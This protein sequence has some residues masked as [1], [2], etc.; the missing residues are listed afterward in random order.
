MKYE[1]DKKQFISIFDTFYESG[2]PF[3]FLI[4]FNVENFFIDKLKNLE[5]SREVLYFFNGKTNSNICKTGIDSFYL[6]KYPIERSLYEKK[7]DRIMKNLKE[8]DSYLL[9]L[10]FPT[11][12]ET[13]LTFE[14]IFLYA[15]ASYK[16][17]MYDDFLFFSPERFITIEN[18]IISTFPMKGTRELLNENSKRLLVEDEKELAEHITVVDLLRNDLSI[19]ADDVRVEKFR[20][21]SEIKKMGTTLLQTSS[22]ISGRIKNDGSLAELI[23]KILPAGSISGAPKRKT[24]E[25]IKNCEIDSRGFY[26]GIAGIFD[27]NMLDSCVI[28]R[29]IE[30]VGNNLFYRSGG[31]ITIY[32]DVDLEYKEMLD[33]IYVPIL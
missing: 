33:K 18:G 6:K 30:R 13:N 14:E 28:I 25:I 12:I 29:F 20:F 32:S 8:G 9:N 10:T 31:G 21:V 7:F 23:L 4:D 1:K 27:G 2:E 22:K 11:K 5:N 15:Q 19:I 26:T 17:K 24:L 16:I 3:L